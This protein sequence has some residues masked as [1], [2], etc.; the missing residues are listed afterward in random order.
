MTNAIRRFP[1][2]LDTEIDWS[3]R[4]ADT[5]HYAKRLATAYI[6][7]AWLSDMSFLL[8]SD[9]T[10]IP[11]HSMIVAAASPVLEKCIFQIGGVLNTDGCVVTI[12]NCPLREFE[13]FLQYI[14]TG[15]DE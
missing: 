8:E 5:S 9:N 7:N 11:G 4:K 15:N 6:G 12:P 2:R 10:S 3:N 14:Y 13:I 1:D